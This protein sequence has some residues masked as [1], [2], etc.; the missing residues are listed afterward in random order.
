MINKEARAHDHVVRGYD[1]QCM[2]LKLAD[3][4]TQALDG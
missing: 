3:H 4:L 1:L 2:A